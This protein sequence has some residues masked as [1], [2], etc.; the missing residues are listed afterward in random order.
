MLPVDLGGGEGVVIDQHSLIS[1]KITDNLNQPQDNVLYSYVLIFIYCQNFACFGLRRSGLSCRKIIMNNNISFEPS[2]E[3]L[4]NQM[5]NFVK[6]FA[7]RVV[8][9]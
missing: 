6:I 8:Q 2:I 1:G 7:T 4:N 9:I 5:R 3:K